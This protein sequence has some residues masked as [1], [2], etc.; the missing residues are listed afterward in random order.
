MKCG[1]AS[2]VYKHVY[3]IRNTVMWTHWNGL[4]GGKHANS[5]EKRSFGCI[6]YRLLN[7]ATSQKMEAI[8]SGL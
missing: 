7:I 6:E 2:P 1:H 4:R 5:S 8:L 3:E